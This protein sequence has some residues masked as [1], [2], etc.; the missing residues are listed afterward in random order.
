[1]DLAPIQALN[2]DTSEVLYLCTQWKRIHGVV[3]QRLERKGWY[4]ERH[5]ARH[6]IYWH[7]DIIAQ[8]RLPRHRTVS[9]GVARQIAKI[10]GWEQ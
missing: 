4:P 1:M 6:D 8:I 5:G 2:H 7:P 9:P 3:R 10:A